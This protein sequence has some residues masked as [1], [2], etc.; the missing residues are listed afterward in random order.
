MI[1]CT[2]LFHGWKLTLLWTA[3]QRFYI[4]QNIRL[5]I[6]VFKYLYL[7]LILLL[8]LNKFIF[9][10]SGC[11]LIY[12]NIICYISFF[13]RTEPGR[14]YTRQVYALGS[15][16]NCLSCR[17]RTAENAACTW[18]SGSLSPS[19]EYIAITCSPVDYPSEVFI[20]DTRVCILFM[21]LSPHN[22]YTFHCKIMNLSEH[23]F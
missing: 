17:L 18:A 21:E 7:L 10:F 23:W 13:T 9:F 4:S 16:Q 15:Q 12:G 2:R 20:F 19:G 14:A 5:G 1:A 8:F 3:R 11:N 22:P 6:T